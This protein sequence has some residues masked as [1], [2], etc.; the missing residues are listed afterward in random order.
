ML[1]V[2]VDEPV[3]WPVKPRRVIHDDGEPT[4]VQVYAPEEIVADKLRAILQQVA[5]IKNRGWSRSIARDYYDLWRVLETYHD[6]PDQTGFPD[7]LQRGAQSETSPFADLGAS[8]VTA[9]SH[10]S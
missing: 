9:C 3:L 7:L 4:D 10:K 1:K 8:S 2:T 5:L 6:Q